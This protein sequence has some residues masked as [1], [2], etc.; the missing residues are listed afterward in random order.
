[1][2]QTLGALGLI[3]SQ[4]VPKLALHRLV[5]GGEP[6]V[7][8]ALRERW[9]QLMDAIDRADANPGAVDTCFYMVTGAASAES[10]RRFRS[11][12]LNA[13]VADTT[14]EDVGR[15]SAKLPARIKT[16]VRPTNNSDERAFVKAQIRWQIETLAVWLDTARADTDLA[17]ATKLMTQLRNL[18]SELLRT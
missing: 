4:K 9:P 5:R 1:V 16:R 7:L 2:V 13:H 8:E 10:A 11:F 3:D 15:R 17:T 18:R 12:V 6:V 14:G